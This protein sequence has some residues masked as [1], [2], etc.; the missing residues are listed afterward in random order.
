MIKL[1]NFL[2]HQQHGD[3]DLFKIVVS[4]EEVNASHQLN[5]QLQHPGAVYIFVTTL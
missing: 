3:I 1:R 5:K 2:Q 4:N